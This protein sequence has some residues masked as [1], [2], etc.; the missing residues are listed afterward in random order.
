[1]LISFLSD[2]YRLRYRTSRTKGSTV[3]TPSAEDA[4]LDL[5]P[6]EFET[7][8]ESGFQI[9]TFQGPLCAE[10]MEGLAFSIES[11]D[12][13]AAQFDSENRT[14]LHLARDVWSFIHSTGD[15]LG[16]AKMAQVGGSLVT[17]SKEACRNGFL[18][19]SPRL[20]MAI[21]TCDIQASSTSISQ[22]DH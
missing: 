15:F 22:V 7:N 2:G 8:I 18:D 16:S 10:P 21:Y 17:A 1:M 12:F 13:D 3:A 5:L 4:T 6:P 20:K 9:A 14:Y 11:I 19:W